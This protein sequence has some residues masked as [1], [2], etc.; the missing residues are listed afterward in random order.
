[1]GRKQALSPTLWRTCRVLMNETRLKLFQTV[2]DHPDE[3]NVS[4]I[5]RCLD[6]PQPH[7]TNGLRSLQARGLIGVRRER[8]SVFY[9]LTPDRSLPEALS[10][11]SA[12]IAYLRGQ[13]PDENWT[14]QTMAVLKAFTHF[15]RLA[16]IRR[17][18]RGPATKREL[19]KV[20]GVVVKTVSHH[21]RFLRLSGLVESAD[22]AGVES[23]FRLRE[24]DNPIAQELLRQLLDGKR[25]YFNDAKGTERNLRLVRDK[26]GRRSVIAIK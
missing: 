16:M 22:V 8:L 2:I 25:S 23:I 5:A 6:I 24:T 3:L 21:L 7:A 1:M 4:Q 9:N 11:Q 26:D 13:D 19:E 18:A 15:N 20:S 12:F 17:L 14:G 10:L